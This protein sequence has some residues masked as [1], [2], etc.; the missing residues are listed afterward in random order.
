MSTYTALNKSA[1]VKSMA[2]KEIFVVQSSIDAN[3]SGQ[4]L[5]SGGLISTTKVVTGD[6]LELID[7]P[8]GVAVIGGSLRIDRVQVGLTT[9]TVTVKIGSAAFT[10]AVTPVDATDF[11]FTL[12][13]NASVRA[14]S[15]A[16]VTIGAGGGTC[17]DNGKYTLTLFLAQL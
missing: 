10:A 15:K 16:T 7:I 1:G 5:D 2:G 3:V 4:I 17:T 13:P 12:L 6:V 14:A 9:P 8:A 11:P